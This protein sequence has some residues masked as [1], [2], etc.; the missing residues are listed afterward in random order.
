MSD[1][2]TL[3]DIETLDMK[4]RAL[5]NKIRQEAIKWFKYSDELSNDESAPKDVLRDFWIER[6]NLT[7]KEL[8]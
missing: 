3:K 4:E 1:L 6:F 7:E 2:K 5:I 8:E